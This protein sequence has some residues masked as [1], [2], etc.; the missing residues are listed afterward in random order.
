MSTWKNHF[1]FFE[2]TGS[3]R[4][5]QY[6]LC[7]WDIGSSRHEERFKKGAEET[8]ITAK[9]VPPNQSS[10]VG[11]ADRPIY[12][13]IALLVPKAIPTLMFNSL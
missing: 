10:V 6:K 13:K 9:N 11:M 4:P 12:V 3:Y 2:H 7:G 5:I 1:H 8:H